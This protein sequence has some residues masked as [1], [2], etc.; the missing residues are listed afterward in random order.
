MKSKKMSRIKHPGFFYFFL[1]ESVSSFSNSSR[2]ISFV[3]ANSARVNSSNDAFFARYSWYDVFIIGNVCAE[4][5]LVAGSSVKNLKHLEGKKYRL[6]NNTLK[7]YS[8]SLLIF[9][10]MI[11]AI[12]SFVCPS[13]EWISTCSHFALWKL[14]DKLARKSWRYCLDCL[15]LLLA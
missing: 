9:S 7:S 15:I 4:K 6:G 5:L 13:L 8:I 3:L 12:F 10:L 14:L 11:S 2:I 1:V